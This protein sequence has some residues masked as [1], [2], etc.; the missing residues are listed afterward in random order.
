MDEWIFDRETHDNS[1]PT[2]ASKSIWSEV[3]SGDRRRPRKGSKHLLYRSACVC[4]N[5]VTSFVEWLL[6]WKLIWADTAHHKNHRCSELAH[7]RRPSL[8]NKHLSRSKQNAP[9]ILML[10]WNPYCWTRGRCCRLALSVYVQYTI[11]NRINSNTATNEIHNH[12]HWGL[13]A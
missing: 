13:P 8:W 5:G 9:P 10:V 2:I 4:W 1:S 7:H 12:G 11:R 6:M 3:F